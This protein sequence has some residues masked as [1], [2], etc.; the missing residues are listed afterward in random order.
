VGIFCC[1]GYQL[2]QQS[3][4][5][6]P[7]SKYKD[8]KLEILVCPVCG[9]LSAVLTQ[10]NIETQKYEIYRPKRKHTARFIKKL[11]NEPW[12][13]EK[14]DCGTKGNAGFIYG[15]NMQTRSGK[16][17]QFAVDFNGQRRLVKV[18]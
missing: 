7:N 1:G 11:Q 2:P 16:I 17:Y 4:I 10:F 12:K 14:L 6:L 5:L 8:R 18:I 3:V 9:G 13:D 15:V